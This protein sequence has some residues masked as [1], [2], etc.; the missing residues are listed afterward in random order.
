MLIFTK[1]LIE[2]RDE[3][4]QENLF[5]LNNVCL[6]F[7]E[8]EEDEDSRDLVGSYPGVINNFLLTR[9]KES[10]KDPEDAGS[11]IFLTKEARENSDYLL[12]PEMIYKDIVE[13]FKSCEDSIERRSLL[14]GQDL[15]VDVNLTKIK[16]LF[17]NETLRKDYKDQISLKNIQISKWANFADLE[18][19]I[20]RIFLNLLNNNNLNSFEYKIYRHE[21]GLKEIFS[22]I[23]SYINRNK[24]FKLLSKE[25]KKSNF[26]ELKISD[27]KFKKEDVLIIE[28]IPKNIITKPFLRNAS[29]TLTCSLCSNKIDSQ[30]AFTCEICTTTIYCSPRC[31]SND[32]VHAEYHKKVSI[33]YKKKM[34][35][36]EI[37]GLKLSHFLDT[38]SKGGLA[39]LKNFGNTD[40][41]NAAIQCLSHCEDLTKYFLSKSFIDEINKTNKYGTEG[42]V[43]KVYYDILQ[44]LWIGSK[45]AIAPWDFKNIF[46]SFL[47]NFGA[48]AHADAKDVILFILTRLHE[49]L[50]RVKEIKDKSLKKYS[51]N[52]NNNLT[53]ESA[54][55][56]FIS[57]DNSIITDY[58]YGQLKTSMRCPSCKKT[59][60]SYDPFLF[61]P[62]KIPDK[63]IPKI[64]FKVF[65]NNFEF[66]FYYIEFFGVDKATTVI[67][68]KNKIKETKPNIEL[69]ALLLKNR[70]MSSLLNDD[71]LIHPHV[72]TQVDYLDEDFVDTEVVFYEVENSFATSKNK[73]DFVTFFVSPCQIFE[74]SYYLLMKQKKFRPLTFPK[75]FS[76][77]KKSKVKDLFIAVYKYY[78]RAMNDQVVQVSESECNTNYYE[79]FYNNL[80]NQEF[81]EKDFEKIFLG[82]N[83]EMSSNNL[84]EGNV[85][86]SPSG[87]VSSNKHFELHLLNNIPPSNSYFFRKPACEYCNSSGCMFCKM[88]LNLL[89]MKIYEFYALQKV[90]RPFFILADFNQH[91]QGFFKFYEEALVEGPQGELTL[92]DAFD[93]FRKEEK[94][95]KDNTWLCPHCNKQLEAFKK[96]DITKLP[97]YFIIG[98]KR[99]KLKG[100]KSL[101]ELVNN[102][103][104]ETYLYY[105]ETDLDL[106]NF[107]IGESKDLCKYDLVS[108]T[109]HS[110]GLQGGH[111]N[112]LVKKEGKWYDLSDE[113]VKLIEDMENVLGPAGNAYLLVYQRKESGENSEMV[114]EAMTSTSVNNMNSIN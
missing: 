67:Q 109:A 44:E 79:E 76:I 95:E 53:S 61:L 96:V 36:N 25:M 51:E 83:E 55:G 114:S 111:F 10:W 56:D 21:R 20:Q 110:G 101:I 85:L 50:N 16:I 89:E 14:M 2:T 107:V 74:E 22:I 32:L 108:I 102:K 63:H 97:K 30:S 88:D 39:G 31:K 71:D 77:N 13:I 28:V 68:V 15:A 113:N 59:T 112:A 66:K 49:D 17:I 5:N 33:L 103:K 58:F 27:M 42:R 90:T 93:L 81:L 106:K 8:T 35:L 86:N 48:G 41:M 64:K 87:N 104:N 45:D 54:W 47:K 94:L 12:V 57:N 65:P 69:D 82:R 73:G 75:P 70:V 4:V 62:L 78:R 92:Y 91:N 84:T 24:T 72:F 23:L 29:E 18:S 6:L 19:K 9:T 52:N 60:T 11:S 3:D 40:F 37:A 99:F 26:E 80:E 100:H 98:F 43:A 7:F 34:S 46:T 38:T 105:P 1:L